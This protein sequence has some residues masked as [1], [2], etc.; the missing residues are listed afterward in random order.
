MFVSIIAMRR[1]L[2]AFS[3]WLTSAILF[4]AEKPL[5]IFCVDVEGGESTLFVTPEVQ[6]LLIDT[7]WPGNAYRDANRIVA[8][9]KLDKIKRINYVLLT[10]YHADHVGGVPQLI[11]KV[12]VDAFIDHAPP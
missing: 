12:P 5:Q 3:I 1:L 8:A 9:M 6:S 2:T 7:C 11:S 4:G 10:H